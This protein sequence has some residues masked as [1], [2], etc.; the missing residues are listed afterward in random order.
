MASPATSHRQLLQPPRQDHGIDGVDAGLALSRTS[1]S[2][3]SSSSAAASMLTGDGT[4]SVDMA[5]DMADDLADGAGDDFSVCTMKT[6][7]VSSLL[8]P[9]PCYVLLLL[10]CPPVIGFLLF[11]FVQHFVAV[12]MQILTDM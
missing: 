3:S 8:M 9:S 10:L 12:L 2:S 7:S 4:V 6:V 11:L 1:S 5:D